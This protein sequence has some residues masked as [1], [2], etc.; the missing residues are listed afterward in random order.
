MARV[1]DLSLLHKIKRHG[2]GQTLDVSACFNCGNCTAVCPL[3]RDSAAFPRRMIRMAQVGMEREVLASEDLWR[4]YACGECTRTCP[5]KADPARF[6]AAARSYAISRYDVT[7]LAGLASRSVI[8]NLLVFAVFSALFSVVLMSKANPGGPTLPLFDFL[9]GLWI[10]DIGVAVFTAVGLSILLGM[11]SMAVRYWRQRHEEG[12]ALSLAALPGAIVTAV[13]DAFYTAVSGRETPTRPTPIPLTNGGT[14]AHG[15]YMPPSWADSSPCFWPPVWI[16]CSSPS[17]LRFRPGIP[18]GSSAPWVAWSASMASPSS[19][20]RRVQ[21]KD[22]VYAKSSVADWFFPILLMLT[23]LTGLLCEIVVYFPSST[24]V[25]HLVFLTHVVL[26][27]DL[28]AMLPLTKF[29]HVL[30]RTLALVLFA[31]RYAPA[32]APP[33]LGRRYSRTTAVARGN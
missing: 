18:C 21:A 12:V 16:S 26:A 1:V 25:G 19:L 33:R 8:G 17:A 7:G 23:V 20:L 2:A 3:A 28:I 29:A 15:S 13:S 30:Y 9:P 27:L 11:G 10:H 24:S 4:C 5:R 32:G 6:M 14:C 22:P 31:W